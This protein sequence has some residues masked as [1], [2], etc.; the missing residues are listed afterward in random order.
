M[1]WASSSCQSV[2]PALA[3]PPVE[4]KEPDDEVGPLLFFDHPGI[5]HPVS[6]GNPTPAKTERARKDRREDLIE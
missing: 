1:T 4:A 6:T 5:L 3:L 2:L